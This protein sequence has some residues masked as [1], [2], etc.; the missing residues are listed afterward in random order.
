MQ[1]ETRDILTLKPHPRNKEWRTHPPEQLKELGHLLSEFGWLRNVVVSSDDY[2]VAGHG[3]VEAA[4]MRG[5]PEVPCVVMP[6]KHDSPEAIKFLVAENTVQAR[7]EVDQTG[8]AAVLADI[9]QQSATGLDG[10]GWDS[11]QLDALIGQLAAADFEKELPDAF[12]EV[13]PTD[14][15]F[16]HRCPRCNFEWNDTDDQ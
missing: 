2:I 10:T 9:Q 13:D 5:E 14:D 7:A 11:G 8:L 15:A 1:L 16:A 4:K 3:I 12:K 6:H